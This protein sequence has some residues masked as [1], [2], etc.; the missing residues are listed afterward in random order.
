MNQDRALEIMLRGDNVM[1]TGPAGAGK[2]YLLNRFIDKARKKRKKVVVTATTGL[3]A[4][5]LN[6]Q[7]IHSWSGIGL[8]KKLHEDYTYMMSETK[9]KAIRKT[10]I[11]IIDEVSMMHDYNLDMVDQAM[12][13]IRES[14]KPMGGIQTILCG[15]FFQLPPVS[16]NGN[17][18]F[19]T[20]SA[21]WK[22]LD[23]SICYLEEQ[24]RAEDLRLQAIL[25]ALRAGNLKQVHLDQ[26][27]SRTRQR[28]SDGVTR[29]YTTNA[30]VDELNQ[31]ELAATPG[32]SHFYMRTSRGR[33]GAIVSLQR[34]VLAPELL[35]LKLGVIV[36]AV[37]NDPAG[38][39][40]NGSIGNVIDFTSEG[41]PVV[42]FKHPT[43]VYPDEWELRSGDRITA[44]I[45]QIPLRL[46]Y[47]ITVHKSQGMTL[48]AAEID[49]R[50]AFVE[51]MGYVALSR[52]RSL[53]NL[54]LKGINR[55][56]LMVSKK[57]QQIDAELRN[58]SKLLA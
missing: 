25:N 45:T 56:A 47:A 12:R 18:R 58:K 52:V 17:G 31:R 33:W 41:F 51:G 37:K 1:L 6:G 54:Y 50:K 36:M 14:D 4:A 48:D 46:A 2:S 35:E 43:V 38:R 20:E 9:K 53:D 30:D 5:H 34:N 55:R 21:T 7:T 57:A 42:N 23:L 49:L 27:L 13:I 39:Y 44:A 8:G 24:Y 29:L 32:D 10:D 16:S 22:R 26:L 19:I 15:D 11:L 3:A 40:H 28:A